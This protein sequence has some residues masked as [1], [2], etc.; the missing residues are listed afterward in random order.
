MFATRPENVANVEERHQEPVQP[1]L[2]SA[3]SVSITKFLTESVANA[4][5]N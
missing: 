1:V 4:C 5:M 2:V 3:V